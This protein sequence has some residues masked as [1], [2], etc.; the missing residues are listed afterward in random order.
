VFILA[1][2]KKEQYLRRKQV[3]E[4]VD[5]FLTIFQKAGQRVF[6][7]TIMTK[8]LGRQIKVYDKEQIMYWFE[9][10]CYE[11]CR[12]NAYPAF[13]S[14]VE[15]YDYENGINKNLLT[16]CILFIDLDEE[17]FD[18]KEELDRWLDEILENVAF[19][20]HG[21]KPLVLWSGNGYHVIL[22]V[23]A[24][25]ALEQYED[26]QFYTKEPSNEFL[27]FARD[28][29]SL[30]KADK[31]NNLSFKSCL[32]RVPH[33]I[34]S[35]TPKH[36]VRTIECLDTSQTFPNIDNI[37]TEFIT[38]LT[39]RKSGT[40]VSVDIKSI[41]VHDTRG[42]A[43]ES[44]VIPYVEKLISMPISN[45]RKFAISL[46]LS[47]YVV[48]IQH[49]PNEECINK[50]KKWVLKCNEVRGLEPSLEYFDKLIRT[51][52]ERC[53]ND[54]KIKPLRFEKTLQ[55]K[56]IIK[57]VLQK[58]PYCFCPNSIYL[59]GDDRKCNR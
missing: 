1:S 11:D 28:F 23:N 53:R 37:L 32:L 10:S 31:R 29:L 56:N 54:P 4:G 27:I 48:N 22:P 49:L 45:H 6:P 35:K 25:E 50:I 57:V 13:L 18:S 24:P 58:Y 41:A 26:F 14:Q 46:I 16:P 43:R 2:S 33:T 17:N 38:P 21:H 30:N 5:L 20:L 7:R 3:S 55:Y 51:S 8:Q 15:E 59:R 34:N 36:E 52:I 9:Q 39:N 42:Q 47:P 40:N 44:N 12:I 19:V